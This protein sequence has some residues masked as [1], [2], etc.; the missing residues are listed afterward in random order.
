MGDEGQFL[1]QHVAGLEIGHDEDIGMPGHQRGDALGPRRLHVH[2][3]VHGKRAVHQAALDLA[4]IGHLGQHR[5]VQ[6]RG[7]ARVDRLDCR[8]DTGLGLRD[9]ERT[10]EVDGVLG[11]VHLAFE[12]GHDV[13]RRIRHQQQVIEPRHV[14]HEGVA[15]PAG[16]SQPAALLDDVAQ[17]R[18][19][20]KVALH[21]RVD[22]ALV[23]HLD[24]ARRGGVVTVGRL[25]RNA[26][27]IGADLGGDG[28][29]PVRRADQ[30][31]ADDAGLGR[32]E[33]AAERCRVLG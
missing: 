14:H 10:R 27:D 1:G 18:I 19:G 11:D 32:E 4:A 28:G 20:M 3:I 6:R 9:A 33:R 31:R 23:N 12:V 2:G 13:H 29:D 25:Q 26:R 8:E 5:R 15:E 22:A 30:N 21:Q 24:G 7:N 17:Q 16:R